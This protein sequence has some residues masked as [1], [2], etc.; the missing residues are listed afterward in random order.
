MKKL[1]WY[2]NFGRRNIVEGGGYENYMRKRASRRRSGKKV[3]W[4]T[5]L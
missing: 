1:S 4:W 3:R 5:G 2:K